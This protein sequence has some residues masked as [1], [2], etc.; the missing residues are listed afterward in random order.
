MIIAIDAGYKDDVTLIP[1]LKTLEISNESISSVFI[2]HADIDHV[3]GVISKIKFAPNAE[4][5]LH[6]DE[7]DMILGKEKRFCVAG[8]KLKNP[9]K[10]TGE[11]TLLED[12]EITTIGE[13]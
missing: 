8:I 2:T 3:G 4:I 10:Y 11:Y 9:I 12:N 7:E 1:S 5:L 6:K 13:I